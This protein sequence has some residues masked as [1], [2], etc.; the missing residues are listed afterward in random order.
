MLSYTFNLHFE[1]YINPYLICYECSGLEISL[2]KLN[3]R[4]KARSMSLE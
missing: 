4:A 2:C 3:I 1:L